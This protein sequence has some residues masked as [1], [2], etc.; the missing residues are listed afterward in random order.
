MSRASYPDCENKRRNKLDKKA[1]GSPTARVKG[2]MSRVS[3]PDCENKRRNKLDEEARGS[4][5]V[6][7]K[8][9][10][11]WTR[12]GETALLQEQKEE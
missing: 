11:S 3:Y 7:A 9:R 4:P 6:E 8:G 5:T 2:R 12:K 1:R 10:I